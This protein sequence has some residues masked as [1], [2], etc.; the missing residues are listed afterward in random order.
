[1]TARSDKRATPKKEPRA[2]EWRPKFLQAL[3]ETC[4]VTE[5]AAAAGVHRGTVYRHR[6]QYP[7]FAADWLDALALG[8]EALEDV[9][10]QRAFGYEEPLHHQGLL[11]GDTVTKYD[12]TL[13]I[14]LLKAHKPD[15][16]EDRQLH[17]H[18][19]EVVVNLDFGEK[20]RDK[21]AP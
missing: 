15:K 2:E 21:R 8:V 14:F 12:T 20:D 7:A 3:S 19:G 18:E 9:A 4:N 16:Y 5:S 6:E 10:H 17:R 13:I 1:M 11:T